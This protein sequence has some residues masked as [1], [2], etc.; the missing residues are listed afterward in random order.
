MLFSFPVCF[1]FSPV[2]SGVDVSNEL[3][4]KIDNIDEQYLS[5]NEQV[6]KKNPGFL[7]YLVI[8]NKASSP[9]SE[10]MIQSISKLT[11]LY[12]TVQLSFIDR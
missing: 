3:D 2:G 7:F 8:N 4:I 12:H 6:K 9:P 11:I 10:P 1:C 5:I